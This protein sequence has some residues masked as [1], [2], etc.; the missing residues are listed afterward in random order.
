[1]FLLSFIIVLVFWFIFILTKTGRAD[2]LWVGSLG[3]GLLHFRILFF[4]RLSHTNYHL[5]SDNNVYL[6]NYVLALCFLGE[7]LQNLE[8]SRPVVFGCV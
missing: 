1:M 3:C 2:I 6:I 4:L 5:V 8:V 7:S